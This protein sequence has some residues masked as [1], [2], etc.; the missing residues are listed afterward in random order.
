MNAVR[1]HRGTCFSSSEDL[2][3][4]QFRDRIPQFTAIVKA[5]NK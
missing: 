2:T 4:R 5:V 3:E 1:I